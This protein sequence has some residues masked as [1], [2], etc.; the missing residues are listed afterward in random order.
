MYQS[1]SIVR[2][3]C[4]GTLSPCHGVYVVGKIRPQVVSVFANVKLVLLILPGLNT[5]SDELE[6][7]FLEFKL[8][9]EKN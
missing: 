4:P 1:V 3:P 6:K 2:R 8:S 7:P 9:L 5:H